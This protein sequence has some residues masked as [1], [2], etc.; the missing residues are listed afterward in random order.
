MNPNMTF[1][2]LPKLLLSLLL[3]CAF[4]VPALVAGD[5][6]STADTTVKAEDTVKVPPVKQKAKPKAKQDHKTDNKTKA[7]VKPK[8]KAKVKTKAK[9]KKRQS[10]LYPRPGISMKQVR[11]RYGEPKSVRKSKGKVKKLWPRITV[12]NYGTHSVY[13]ERHLVLHTVIH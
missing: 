2:Y 1:K 3:S 12:W 8:T 10:S 4:F 7:K 6:K 9:T 11:K 13:F 5:E